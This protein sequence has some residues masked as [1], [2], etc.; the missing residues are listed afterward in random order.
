MG[1]AIQR[2]ESGN[3]GCKDPTHAARRQ[4]NTKEEKV[5]RED[6]MPKKQ[7]KCDHPA[8]TCIV[9]EDT[10][11]CSQYCEDAGDIT[12]L[13]CNCAHAGCAVEESQPATLTP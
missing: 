9:S 12:E 4:E 1:A 8:C 13:S 10:D 6:F 7:K 3:G 11:Y 2:I 5:E